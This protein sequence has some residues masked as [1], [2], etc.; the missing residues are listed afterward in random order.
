M[1]ILSIDQF[2]NE[3]I[4]NDYVKNGIVFIFGKRQSN[5]WRGFYVS[6]VEKITYYKDSLYI[7]TLGDSMKVIKYK[8]SKLEAA[9]IGV[10]PTTLRNF[11]GIGTFHVVLNPTK[12]PFY[13][14]TVQYDDL[15]KVLDDYQHEILKLCKPTAPSSETLITIPGFNWK[16]KS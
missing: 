9:E 14:E 3:T 8:D 5:G 2:I 12:T 15:Q 6:T 10:E 1:S 7:A 4:I 11:I 13:K 16:T